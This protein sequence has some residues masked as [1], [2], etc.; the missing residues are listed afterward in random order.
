MNGK[1]DYRVTL[2]YAYIPKNAYE[3]ELFFEILLMCEHEVGAPALSKKLFQRDISG[4]NFW[5]KRGRSYSRPGSAVEVIR[6][7]LDFASYCGMISK[8]YE[9]GG[10]RNIAKYQ[11]TDFGEE[12][13][14][15]F[16]DRDKSVQK[17][18]INALMNYRVG[19]SQINI[20]KYHEFANFRVRPFFILLKLLYLFEEKWGLPNIKFE[21][22]DLG[23]VVLSTTNE[24][25]ASIASSLQT[26]YKLAT[27]KKTLE[28]CLADAGSNIDEFKRKTN[29]LVTRLFRW[30]YYCG[31]I[32]CKTND[33]SVIDFFEK[34]DKGVRV[35]K[36]IGISK[37]GHRVFDGIDN[38]FYYW[39][40]NLHPNEV[41]ILT[42]LDNINQPINRGEIFEELNKYV[43]CS[44]TRFERQLS[45]LQAIFNVKQHD[46]QLAL[47][48]TPIFD[49]PSPNLIQ[50]ANEIS[51]DINPDISFEV[52]E[53]PREVEFREES[54]RIFD[55]IKD[56][57]LIQDKTIDDFLNR[58]IERYFLDYHLLA[59]N[60]ESL[61][62]IYSDIPYQFEVKTAELF[63]R[64]NFK[65]E[66]Y[67]QKKRGTS[68]VDIVAFWSRLL[69]SHQRRDHI[70]V[71]ECKSSKNPYN[72]SHKDV[73]DRVRQ[74]GNLMSSRN[75]K[76]VRTL[77]NSLLFVSSSW[78]IG[79]NP[80][81][82]DM[83]EEKILQQLNQ[84]I[85]IATVGSKELLYLYTKYKSDPSTFE[86]FNFHN[87][88]RNKEITQQDIDRIFH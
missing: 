58:G 81:K 10:K 45:R 3:D 75:Y 24:E 50:I 79:D 47:S 44:P 1:R 51:R 88:F 62:S 33:D 41:I 74:I 20:R 61:S 4:N 8:S 13:S 84:Q 67:G 21:P 18:I 36:V 69:G 56:K 25:D 60:Y 34:W 12:V 85:K 82:M 40:K 72:L 42:V 14:K 64:M 9:F 52:R 70:T 11:I 71:I 66:S 59:L 53:L 83:I 43:E 16:L 39:E 23:F 37:L 80:E 6:D 29:N 30:P 77:I 54:A 32:E 27:N 5:E 7:I 22:Y 68:S 63:N 31:L 17:D 35:T 28:E 86:A 2:D 49:S 26:L 57:E 55:F 15:K 46:K 48:I 78:G 73:D 19:N 87:L 76:R 65:V 38:T